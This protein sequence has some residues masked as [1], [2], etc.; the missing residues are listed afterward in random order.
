MSST[1]TDQLDRSGLLRSPGQEGQ[2][3]VKNT[4]TGVVSRAR[5]ADNGILLEKNASRAFLADPYEVVATDP[6]KPVML[7]MHNTRSRY[8]T[9]KCR[10]IKRGASSNRKLIPVIEALGFYEV[11]HC[12]YCQEKEDLPV[13]ELEE[14]VNYSTI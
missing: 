14:L 2:V 5:V 13:S 4:N 6:D 8:H 3:A 10:S 1:E 7:S 11:D 9:A 12:T